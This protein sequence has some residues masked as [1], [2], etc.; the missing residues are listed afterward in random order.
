MQL[1]R[2]VVLN[3]GGF[4]S[5]SFWPLNE[6]HVNF[7]MSDEHKDVI[8]LQ[9]EADQKI[10]HFRGRR[11]ASKKGEIFLS[12][13]ICNFQ[14][15]NEYQFCFLAGFDFYERQFLGPVSDYIRQEYEDWLD[16]VGDEDEEDDVKDPVGRTDEAEESPSP[17]QSQ[18]VDGNIYHFLPI[19]KT[20]VHPPHLGQETQPFDP[21]DWSEVE[22]EGAERAKK[23]EDVK[24]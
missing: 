3:E 11:F 5:F 6:S 17:T 7:K 10:I 9:S 4:P 21:R 13:F 20:K 23:A 1:L 15:F 2:C 19:P 16:F 24:K 12:E 14:K 18:A 22:A 8:D